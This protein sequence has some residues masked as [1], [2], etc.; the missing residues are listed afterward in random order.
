MDCDVYACERSTC[1]CAGDLPGLAALGGLGADAGPAAV[2]GTDLLRRRPR[3]WY[4]ASRV[5]L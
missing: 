1:V 2:L 5:F 3:M 4:T